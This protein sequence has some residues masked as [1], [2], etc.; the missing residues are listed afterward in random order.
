MVTK[1]GLDL[2]YAN[3]TVSDTMAGIYREQSVALID[4]DSRRIISV[5]KSAI[6]R[7]DELSERAMLVRPFKNGLLFDR[8][9]TQSIVSHVVGE[10]P[11]DER[12]RC[13]I[14][15]PS[16]LIAKQEREVFSIL[17]DAGIAECYAVNRSVAALIGAGGSPLDSVISVNVGA[18]ATEISV[19]YNGSITHTSRTMIGGEDFDKA[20]KQYIAEQG[21]VNVS[22]SV[23]R[24]IKEQLGSVW[25]GKEE[26]TIEIEGTLSL[27]GNNVRMN[28]SSE[29]I[30][31]VFE[32]P[33]HSLL[34]AVAVAIKNIPLDQVKQV[35]KG[36]IVLTGGGSMIHGLNFMME[37]VLGISVRQPSDPI[38]SVAKGLSII[39]SKV[40]VRGKAGKKNIS[41]SISK[42]FKDSK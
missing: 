16:D 28:I 27:T 21:G 40:P 4:R 31:G 7:G 1:I 10:I 30:V 36:G 22:L 5:G 3:I 41:D 34:M 33:L 23:A 6:E 37:K 25:Q 32:K 18:S 20:V 9:I 15:I 24:A 29:D 11:K 13:V 14:G 19:F 8:Q 12:L 38:D 35:F 26:E 42:Y 39:N 17:N 2:G